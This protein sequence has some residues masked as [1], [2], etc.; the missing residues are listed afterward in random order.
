MARVDRPQIIRVWIEFCNFCKAPIWTIFWLKSLKLGWVAFHSVIFQLK[1]LDF[2]SNQYKKLTPMLSRFFN[3]L[4]KKN[5]FISFSFVR[6]LV[7]YFARN[8]P[9]LTQKHP[10]E[11]ATWIV[12]EHQEYHR[13]KCMVISLLLA[14]VAGV[15]LA[16]K[17]SFCVL[18][19]PNWSKSRKINAGSRE[20]M[21]R[22]THSP[23]AL[24]IYLLSLSNTCYV[25][26]IIRSMIKWT[27]PYKEKKVQL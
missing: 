14:W 10:G 3:G 21:G 18:G 8:L 1:C 26:Y 19:T 12:L 6:F 23:P 20:V 16:M 13:I 27:A 7:N 4:W 17:S 24:S 11:T 15:P 25:G 5:D 22:E 9:R 2:K